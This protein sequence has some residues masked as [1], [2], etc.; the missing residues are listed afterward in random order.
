VAVNCCVVL[1]AIEGLIG[2]TAIDVSVAAVTVRVVDPD[3]L[4][5]V[6]LIV[7]EPVA[8][9]VANPWD[10]AALL[11]VATPVLDELQVTAVVR[12]CVVLSE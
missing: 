6:A 8:T 5:D 4:P 1:F 3:I 10:P 12:F 11:M 2:V 7:V 9:G